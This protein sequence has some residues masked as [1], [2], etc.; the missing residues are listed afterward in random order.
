LFFYF[1]HEK[2]FYISLYPTTASFH[3]AA[4]WCCNSLTLKQLHAR[5]A[6]YFVYYI[7]NRFAFNSYSIAA[8]YKILVNS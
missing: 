6:N 2:V 4:H 7:C 1:T 5:L 8:Y 3:F